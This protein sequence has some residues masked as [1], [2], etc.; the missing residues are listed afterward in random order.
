MIL[1]DHRGWVPANLP[2][3]TEA[4][5][6]KMR[7]VKSGF[8]GAGGN[9]T[10]LTTARSARWVYDADFFELGEPCYQ[11]AAGYSQVFET[12][13][14]SFSPDPTGP[15][16]MHSGFALAEL[17]AEGSLY[18]GASVFGSPTAFK[19]MSDGCTIEA[20]TATVISPS[21]Y[22]SYFVKTT[23]TVDGD[24]TLSSTYE[25]PTT[26]P[27][28]S[29]T[30]LAVMRD[31]TTQSLGSFPAQSHTT[32]ISE[33]VS[34]TGVV[35]EMWARKRDG[36]TLGYATVMSMGASAGDANALVRSLR[37]PA[38]VAM[39]NVPGQSCPYSYRPYS[40]EWTLQ[41]GNPSI[42]DLRIKIG[43]P[44]TRDK[45]NVVQPRWPVQAVPA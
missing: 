27:R 11:V 35:Q 14:E 26:D 30:I 42:T 22:F 23:T 1:I 39:Y 29:H 24:G 2:N 25:Y 16:F 38:N 21:A 4:T 44:S 31:G 13:T 36:S 10:Q 3:K 20:A 40:E 19:C 18:I 43:W 8:S 5:L 7:W 28:L 33:V 41:W 37:Q 34:L 9:V 32:E 12:Y 17:A 6:D 45:G 15:M